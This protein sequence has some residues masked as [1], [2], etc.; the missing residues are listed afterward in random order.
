MLVNKSCNI[1][2]RLE[3]ERGNLNQSIQLYQLTVSHNLDNE[4]DAAYKRT[5]NRQRAFQR[6]YNKVQRSHEIYLT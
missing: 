4:I 1:Y 6:I 5:L 2:Q 3:K